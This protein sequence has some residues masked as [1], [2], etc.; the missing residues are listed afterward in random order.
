MSK[1][2]YPLVPGPFEKSWLERNARWKIALG[3][4][5]VIGLVFAFVVGV[6]L[7]VETGFRRSEIYKQALARAEQSPEVRELVG[8]PVVAGIATGS[9]HLKDDSGD[10]DLSIPIS[11][12]KGK[13]LIH[14]IAV[15]NGGPWQFRTLQAAI[16]GRGESIDLLVQRPAEREF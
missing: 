8:V 9:I 7:L 4:L 16:E 13:G 6:L 10:A 2:P 5:T 12:A 11:G 14:L 1:P 15:K 3:C